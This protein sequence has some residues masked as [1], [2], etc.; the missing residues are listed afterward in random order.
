MQAVNTD[1]TNRQ[2][3]FVAPNGGDNKIG[4]VT[5]ACCVR[6]TW[7]PGASIVAIKG[8]FTSSERALDAIY[9]FTARSNKDFN[10]TVAVHFRFNGIDLDV[11]PQFRSTVKQKTIT[12]LSE[13]LP[14]RRPVGN[15]YLT[16][17][18]GIVNNRTMLQNVRINTG[19]FYRSASNAMYPAKFQCTFVYEPLP[20]CYPGRSIARDCNML[21]LNNTRDDY[22]IVQL[23][24]R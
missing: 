6:W 13:E 1:A 20:H 14:V 3:L 11:L 22:V 7:H 24:S 16:T 2:T 18:V 10:A 5:L 19:S 15:R 23:Q 8:S 17:P 4:I 9:P 21:G 12:E